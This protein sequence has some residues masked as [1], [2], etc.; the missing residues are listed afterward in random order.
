M[1]LESCL[2]KEFLSS[3]KA[4]CGVGWEGCILPTSGISPLKMFPQLLG[5][6]E[7]LLVAKHTTVIQTHPTKL[8]LVNRLDVVPQVFEAVP[9]KTKNVKQTKSS[10]LKCKG[11]LHAVV[12]RTRHEHIGTIIPTIECMK[13]DQDTRTHTVSPSP[14]A[15]QIGH[16]RDN[17][18][19]IAV[20]SALLAK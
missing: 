2:V 18:R 1:L 9:V 7:A 20:A 6:V 4:A 17:L 14:L 16:L 3:A 5:V 13:Y 11:Q 8:K 12:L 19:R 15:T 10:M